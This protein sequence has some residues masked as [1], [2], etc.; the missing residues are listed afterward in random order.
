MN[1]IVLGNG[2]SGKAAAELLRR[3]GWCVHVLDGDDT[4]P[5]GI[6]NLCVTSPGIP[7]DHRWQEVARNSGVRIISEL[8]L[9]AE[10]FRKIGGRMLAV[11]GSKGKS[12]VV[13]LVAEAL[14]GIPCGNYGK[15]LCEVALEGQLKWAVVEVSSFQME[16]TTLPPDTLPGFHL[17]RVES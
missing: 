6:W 4:W 5:D 3:E 15:P 17:P 10:R 8:Q 1:A 16:T 9:G 13:K 14:G 11:T 12:S 7:L 2:R